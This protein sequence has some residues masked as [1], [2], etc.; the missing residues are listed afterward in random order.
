MWW[1]R[2][3][4]RKK[5]TTQLRVGV[6]DRCDALSLS[7]LVGNCD[8]PLSLS[9]RLAAVRV[10]FGL[11][12]VETRNVTDHFRRRDGARRKATAKAEPQG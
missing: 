7:F 5:N 11:I 3:A 8:H 1:V 12:L 9:S 4:E 2:V 10:L 6:S